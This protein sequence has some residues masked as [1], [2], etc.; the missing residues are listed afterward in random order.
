MWHTIYN[1]CQT[2]AAY[3]DPNMGFQNWMNNIQWLRGHK[4]SKRHI[5]CLNS[6]S[7]FQTAQVNVYFNRKIEINEG[8]FVFRPKTE[9]VHVL[10][11]C[12]IMNSSLL[13]K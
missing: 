4:T 3:A 13:T 6:I 1:H 9:G 8:A 7:I 12:K 2:A 5:Q 11:L 10:F